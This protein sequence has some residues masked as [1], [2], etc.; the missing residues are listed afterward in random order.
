[1]SRIALLATFLIGS[2]CAFTFPLQV[3]FDRAVNFS[4]YKT[5]RLV[6]P[7]GAP[8]GPAFL[9]G[10]QERIPGWVEERLAAQGLKPVA[11]G[12]DL[13]VSYSIRVTEHSQ[14][15][16]LSDGVGPTGLGS[17]NVV[18]TAILRTI[19]EWTLAVNV[20]DA[21]RNHVVFEGKL[22]L[23]T[24]STAERNAK[25]LTKGFHEILANYPP[26]P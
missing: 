19:Y 15:I 8:S 10:V 4:R 21:K 3:N 18:Y 25:K 24:S 13:V 23:T 14:R 16:N 7:A 12:G 20:V 2:V 6:Q 1:M 5:Y 22:S 9:V 11:A 17:G 26:R